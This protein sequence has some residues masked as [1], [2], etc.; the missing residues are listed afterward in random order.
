VLVLPQN[1]PGSS[2]LTGGSAIWVKMMKREGRGQDGKAG[3]KGN[4]EKMG[5]NGGRRLNPRCEILHTLMQCLKRPR[6][7]DR[8]LRETQQVRP[9]HVK[10][11]QNHNDQNNRITTVNT[12][13]G[14]EY[15]MTH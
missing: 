3:V 15:H 9:L 8:L 5:V 1:A 12:G 14:Q 7:S 2:G 10:S 13:T 4:S 11:R 6:Q